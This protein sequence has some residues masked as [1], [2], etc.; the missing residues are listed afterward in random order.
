[1]KTVEPIRDMEKL[2]AFK[3]ALKEKGSRDYIMALIGLNT[4]LRIS[5]ILDLTVG[6]VR[7]KT[8]TTIIEEKTGKQRKIYW[9]NIY[10]EIQE[11][12]TN[13]ADSEYLIASRQGGKLER[14]QA[15]RIIREAG[16][17]A[18]IE[19]L[20][21]HSLRKTFG[22]HYYKKT[23]DVALLMQ[24]FNHSSPSI[25]LRYIGINDDVIQN[26]MKDFKL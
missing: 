3:A 13:K 7:E 5:D 16:E 1:M 2:Q 26:S 10:K 21:T 20:G 11:F 4:G 22:Y 12:I 25:T 17:K 8:E 15:W 24:I 9:N 14:T 23:Q 18:K 6:Q 19:K